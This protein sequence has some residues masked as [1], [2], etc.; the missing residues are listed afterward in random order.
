MDKIPKTVKKRWV[1]PC[2]TVYGDMATL[3]R[4][5]CGPGC[6]PKVVGMGDDFSTNI[7]TV[8]GP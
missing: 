7:S 5:T 8:G 6:N 4:Q 3:T 2:L 1:K